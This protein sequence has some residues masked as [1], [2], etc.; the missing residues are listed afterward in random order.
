VSTKTG[1]DHLLTVFRTAVNVSFWGYG[2]IG[3]NCH[4]AITE[5]GN[6]HYGACCANGNVVTESRQAGAAVV[7]G[8]N[9]D[10]QTLMP[11]KDNKQTRRAFVIGTGIIG[12]ICGLRLAGTGYAVTF[13][14]QRESE[15][16]ASFGNA[17]SIASWAFI[18]L[19]RASA[20][21]HPSRKIELMG[22]I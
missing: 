6:Q 19:R 8:P 9:Y 14:D 10:E 1:E 22:L 3:K 21:C 7:D 20:T 13:I 18:M 11:P 15:T 5:N 12:V 2:N 17:G 4:H 16:A